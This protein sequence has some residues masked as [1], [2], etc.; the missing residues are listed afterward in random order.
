M[1]NLCLALVPLAALVSLI[2]TAAVI[3]VSRALNA[4]DGWG[5]AGQVKEAPRRVPNTGGVA[6]VLGFLLP[7][8]TG[9]LKLRGIDASPDADWRNDFTLLPADLHEHLAGIQARTPLALLLGACVLWLHVLGLIDDRRPLGA[10][11]K[12]VVMA[13]PAIALPLLTTLS[14]QLDDTRLLTLLDGR[15]G[16]V[17][18][19]IGLTAVWF[20]VVT[21]ALN[22]LDNMDGLA[23]GVAA[24]AGS[25]LLVG[26][27][28]NEQW[29]VGACLALLVGAC[30]GFLAYNAPRRGGAKIFMGD[31]GSLV[32]GFLLAF[33]T[34]RATY[35]APDDAAA[36][37]LR[38]SGAW[39]ALLT[40]LVVLAVPLYDFTSVVLIRLSQGRSP[41]VGDLQHLSHRLVKRGLSKRVAVYVI[42]ALTAVSGVSGLLLAR[43]GAWEAVLI[44]VQVVVLVGVI[45]AVEYASAGKAENGR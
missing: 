37:A 28:R 14:P 18:L 43:A 40:P 12:L 38:G 30:L 34:V 20:L 45:A 13:V 29:F 44:G 22:F 24:V 26:A 16:G 7:L 33:L 4:Y 25:L 9:V 2:A 35:F 23:G 5:V 32:L 1:I 36:R 10:W 31:G 39:Y 15:V 42:W 19:S 11:P 21:N 3:R 17:W 8:V 41:F 27:L 6:I